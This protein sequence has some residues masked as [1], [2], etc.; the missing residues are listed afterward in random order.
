MAT[1]ITTVKFTP[2][3]IGA[4]SDTTRRSAAFKSAAKKMG[5]KVTDV[6]W[7]L[8]P[9]DGVIIFD[10][11]DDKAATAAM[12]NLSAR[13]NVQTSTSRAFDAGEMEKI[14]GMLGK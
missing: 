14:V 2:Q 13:G 8:G 7:T 10:A 11:P 6:Y 9:F 12:L 5:V 1:Y 3:G 4:I